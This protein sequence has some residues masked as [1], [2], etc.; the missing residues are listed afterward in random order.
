[1]HFLPEDYIITQKRRRLKHDAVPSVNIR[2]MQTVTGSTEINDANTEVNNANTEIN[3]A[4]SEI[5]DANTEIND[6]NSEIND[7]NT[8]INDTNT[9]INDTNNTTDIQLHL[10]SETNTELHLQSQTSNEPKPSTSNFI[11]AETN[12]QNEQNTITHTNMINNPSRISRNILGSVTRQ[13]HLTPKA[14]EIYKK[15]VTLAKER[16]RMKRQIIYYKTRLKDAKK[17]SNTQ[18]CKM[19]NSLTPTQRL[20][21]N[22]QLRNTKYAPKVHF[23]ILF[24]ELKS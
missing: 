22:M 15:A 14:Q 11:C 20:F 23:K 19:F 6:A 1:L 10:Q 17:L 18:F 16:N 7:T 12:M 24:D 3:D 8:E 5:N 21:F 4:N 13:R 2:N 9:E